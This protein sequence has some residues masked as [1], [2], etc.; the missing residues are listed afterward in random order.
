MDGALQELAIVL[1]AATAEKLPGDAALEALPS[2]VGLRE[3]LD[4]CEL[5]LIESARASGASWTRVAQAL[6]LGSRQAAEQRFLRLSGQSTRDTDAARTARRGQRFVDAI[7]GTG[8]AEL[9]SAVRRALA[10]MNLDSVWDKRF[11]RAALCRNSLAMAADAQPGALF[12]L[13][14]HVLVDLA[15]A[16]TGEPVVEEVRRCLVQAL[17]LLHSTSG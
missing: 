8:I 6:G 11:P 1:A 15:A 7:Y 12:A 9:R 17:S 3:R 2:I 13:T 5:V 4:R 10:R 16:P 14:E